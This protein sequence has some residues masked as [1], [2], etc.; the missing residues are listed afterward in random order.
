MQQEGATSVFLCI[1]WTKL[2]IDSNEDDITAKLA[3]II[4]HNQ[5]LKIGLAKGS[6][7]TSQLMEQWDLLQ[8]AV[9]LYINSD[10]PGVPSVPVRYTPSLK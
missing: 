2:T 5:I 1:L 8:L 7:T 9:A 10:L 4:Q 3:E 6:P